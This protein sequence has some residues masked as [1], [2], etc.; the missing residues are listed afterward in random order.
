VPGSKILVVDD[1]EFVREGLYETLSRAGYAV[2]TCESGQAALLVLSEG[3]ISVLIT[4]LRMPEMSG[5]ELLKKARMMDSSLPVIMVTAF[6]TVENAVEAMKEGAYDYI[7]KP[8]K[9]DAI[10][11][12][13]AKALE[14]RRLVEE[15]EYLKM[16]LQE[17]FSSENFVG[18]SQPMLTL[19]DK[20]KAVAASDSTVLVRGESGTGKELAAGAIHT[21]SSRSARPFIRVNCAALS[22]G[23][24]ESELFGH[25]KGAFTGADKRRIGRFELAEGGTILLD[26]ISEMDLALQGKLLRVLQE[27]EYERVGSSETISTDVRV[28]ATS[29]RD[30]EAAISSG[31][32]RQD[33]FYRLNVVPLELP[34]LRER[35]DDVSALTEFF[36]DKHG[37][38]GAVRAR[39]ISSEAA[40]LLKSYS[41]PG[42]VRELE[43][44]I[45]RAVVLG[46]S[47]EIGIEDISFGI[48]P[49]DS[50]SSVL[51][52]S[53][54]E[55][56]RI[57]TVAEVEKDHI[58]SVLDFYDNHRQ[59]TA[60]ALGISERSLRDKL[61]KW[62][63]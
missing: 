42:N 47:E 57:K 55:G 52:E 61:K 13:V 19:F 56:G 48:S 6:A 54:G 45:E 17:K 30:L 16:E 3:D 46:Q 8:F 53:P 36:I 39:S 41:W 12:V 22:A 15:N 10:E 51:A 40:A 5:I 4:D 60:T 44:I 28:I 11:I 49:D 1:Q 58:L 59:K 34:P 20:I 23:L 9:A 26:E 50:S 32:F 38:K 37:S 7:M 2:E 31:T 63:E 14:H 24:L 43:N 62:K 29:N 35:K 33:L 18:G 21:Q 27:K 25:E